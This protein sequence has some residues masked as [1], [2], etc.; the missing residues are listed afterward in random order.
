MGASATPAVTATAAATPAKTIS[1]TPDPYS[2]F[3]VPTTKTNPAEKP[4][5][6]DQTTGSS[7][8]AYDE[9]MQS[10]ILKVF[11][12]E[13]NLAK[14]FCGTNGFIFEFIITLSKFVGSIFNNTM[15]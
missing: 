6:P 10:N 2:P 3:P 8:K 13:E 7:E 11:G 14:S 5:Y 1:P 12:F 15:M 9:C 4:T